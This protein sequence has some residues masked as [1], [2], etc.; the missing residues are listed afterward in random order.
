VLYTNAM[1]SMKG[2]KV[3]GL[4][5][6]ENAGNAEICGWC[7]WNRAELVTTKTCKFSTDSNGK[8]ILSEDGNPR[9]IHWITLDK[10][11]TIHFAAL[12]DLSPYLKE[13]L[14]ESWKQLLDFPIPPH[15]LDA[16]QYPQ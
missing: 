10:D 3:D 9:D 5:Y 1:A 7:S 14:L 12:R 6:Q 4:C 2:V 15:F 11:L 16:I 13:R 8:Q